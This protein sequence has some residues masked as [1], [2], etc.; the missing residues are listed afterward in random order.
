MHVEHHALNKDFP[1]KQAQLLKLSLENPGFARKAEAY[2]AL[3][4]RIRSLEVDSNDAA[5]LAALKQ[6]HTALKDDIARDLKRASG[7]CCG[8][9]CG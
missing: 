9:C 3:D 4:Q 2:E 5:A 6:E 7:S 8:G 1:E